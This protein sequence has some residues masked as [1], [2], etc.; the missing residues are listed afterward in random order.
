MNF[1]SIDELII[2]RSKYIMARPIDTLLF[3]DAT[4]ATISVPPVEPL[5]INTS[6]IPS[7]HS[8]APIIISINV[9]PSTGGLVNIGWNSANIV[10]MTITPKS[11]R[12][13]NVRPTIFQA[14]ISIRMFTVKMVTE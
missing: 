12:I 5:W 14:I 4:A 10:V 3:F 1:S 7:P 2:D 13:T 9:C 8:T 11:V 6:P